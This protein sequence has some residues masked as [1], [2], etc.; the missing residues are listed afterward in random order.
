MENKETQLTKEEI[1]ELKRR[2]EAYLAN[3]ESGISLEVV[4][5]KFLSKYNS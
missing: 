4:K 1:E 5:K 2:R 3:P